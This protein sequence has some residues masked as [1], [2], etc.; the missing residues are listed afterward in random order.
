MAGAGVRDPKLVK[1]ET[2]ITAAAQSKY[3]CVM[4]I[5]VNLM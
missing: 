5:Y 1:I 3:V 2:H 4:H